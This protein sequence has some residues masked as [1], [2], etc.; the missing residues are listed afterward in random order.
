[1]L[2]ADNDYDASVLFSCRLSNIDERDKMMDK[3]LLHLRAFQKR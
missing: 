1:M 2:N 3:E